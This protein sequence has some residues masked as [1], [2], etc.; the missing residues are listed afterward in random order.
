MYCPIDEIETGALNVE[1]TKEDKDRLR[2]LAERFRA[3]AD[4]DVMKERRQGWKNKN[5]LQAGYPMIY[6]PA[7]DSIG[8]ITP[9][10]IKCTNRYLINVEMMMLMQIKQFDI[11]ED[12]IV[13]EP[14]YSLAWSV[15]K[16]D[17][18]PDIKVEMV[19][20]PQTRAN[21]P[22]HPI[23]DVEDLKKLQPR[24]FYVDRERTLDFQNT[25][26]DIF[27]DILPVYAEGIFP[28][29]ADPGLPAQGLYWPAITYDAFLLVGND[30]LMT[31]PF[32]EPDALRWLIDF[33]SED[34]Q[35]YLKWIIDE[36]LALS[37]N[38]NQGN[39]PCQLGYV[40]DLPPFSHEPL[41][42]LMDSWG[43][44]ESQETMIVSPEMFAEFYLPAL[45]KWGNSFGML[46]YSCCEQIHDRVGLIRDNFPKLRNLTIA[47]WTNREQV[48]KEM[49]T[50]FAYTVKAHPSYLSGKEPNWEAAEKD[51]QH[52]YDC[53]K[54]APLS[55]GFFEVFD[56]NNDPTRQAQWSRMVKKIIGR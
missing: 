51:I 53:Y 9:D 49:G 41:T 38:D 37:N 33:I 29:N 40:S 52:A 25:L 46:S 21:V 2:S 39:A 15:F 32:D 6:A 26:N 50:G 28:F 7:G 14:H 31:W 17:Y 3:A 43:W 20:N 5:D 45:S 23:H 24:D 22:V 12:D 47:P 44:V 4:S 27:G 34:R 36:R 55:F 18:G 1:A 19:A 16:P 35:R 56:I 11:C 30:N 8:F 54:D 10:E 42:T 13:L 48:Y